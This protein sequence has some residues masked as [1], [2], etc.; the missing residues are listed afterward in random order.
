VPKAMSHA[1]AKLKA[2]QRRAEAGPRQLL[3]EV[4]RP[5]RKPV[6]NR[7]PIAYLGNGNAPLAPVER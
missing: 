6:D 4:R 2:L 3:C 5:I 1:N 7:L